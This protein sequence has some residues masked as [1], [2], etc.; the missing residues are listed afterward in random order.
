M[1]L[2][3]P[4]VCLSLSSHGITFIPTNNTTELKLQRVGKNDSRPIPAGATHSTEKMP[5]D[6]GCFMGIESEYVRKLLG[7]KHGILSFFFLQA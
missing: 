6:L 1:P 2:P 3:F 7:Q 5:Y 4:F